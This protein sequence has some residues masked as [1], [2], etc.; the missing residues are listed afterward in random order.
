MA[1]G[2]RKTV[3]VKFNVSADGSISNIQVVQSAGAAFD[4]E[5]LRVMARMPKWK[6]AIENGK[7][8]NAVITQPVTFFGALAS[9]K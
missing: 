2:E 8:A 6:S 3:V 1:P 5:V 7:P 4:A 9:P